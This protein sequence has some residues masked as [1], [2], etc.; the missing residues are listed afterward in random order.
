MSTGITVTTPTVE[1]T[2]H[3]IERSIVSRP[4]APTGV[5][6]EAPVDTMNTPNRNS[7]QVKMAHR[8]AVVTSPGAD[9]GSSTRASA[10]Q[11]LQPSISAA[12]S[13]SRLTSSKKPRISQTTSGMSIAT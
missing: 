1:V 2:F 13:I 7:F 10:C 3:S 5:V 8:M 11:R 9:S 6:C 12:S 4:E